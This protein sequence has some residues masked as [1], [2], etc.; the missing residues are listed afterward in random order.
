[1]NF[2]VT[3]LPDGWFPF[4]IRDDPLMADEG[5]AA[6]EHALLSFTDT[7]LEAD[8][9]SRIALHRGVLAA[10]SPVFRALIEQFPDEPVLRLGNRTRDDLLILTNALYPPAGGRWERFTEA[11]VFRLMEMFREYDMRVV[12]TDAED[13]MMRHINVFCCPPPVVRNYMA[14]RGSCDTEKARR[15]V[16]TLVAAHEYGMERLYAEC[17]SKFADVSLS[18]L[19]VI[20]NNADGGSLTGKLIFDLVNACTD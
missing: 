4:A 14:T 8:D 12:A 17:L 1:M 2:L 16:S 18:E 9:G 3:T 20:L 6:P 15:T 11:T 10:H 7:S 13:W 5:A 19:R